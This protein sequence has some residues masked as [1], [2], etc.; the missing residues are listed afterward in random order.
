M[1]SARSLVQHHVARVTRYADSFL[2]S[3]LFTGPLLQSRLSTSSLEGTQTR[4]RVKKSDLQV[5]YLY[6][7]TDGKL[8][9]EAVK[10]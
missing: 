9:K 5:K 1:Q 4:L 8:V 7:D 10:I 3:L 2:L 6:F